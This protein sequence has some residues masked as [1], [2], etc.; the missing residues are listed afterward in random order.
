MSNPF[1]SLARLLK[2]LSV[3]KIEVSAG[4][5]FAKLIFD[6]AEF[7]AL[8]QGQSHISDVVAKCFVRRRVFWEDIRKENRE[9]TIKSLEQV[10]AQLDDLSSKLAS[11]ADASVIA[12][13]KFVRA[14]ATAASLVRKELADR[15]RDIDDEKASTLGYD[16]ANEDRES[17]VYDALIS[18]RQRIYP[19]VTLLVSILPDDDPTKNEA[20]SLLDS[21]LNL[22][23]N[24][25]LQ[26]G[27][28]PEVDEADA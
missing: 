9:A 16:W 1:K 27:C 18:V 23:P 21:G 14:W 19:L 8:L 13:A 25:A 7:H 22:M 26:R 17:A 5:P 28:I 24:A 11:N 3:N 15:L 6:K 4:P 10:E 20:Q 2:D 12:L